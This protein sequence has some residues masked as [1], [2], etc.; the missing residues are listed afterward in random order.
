M[1]KICLTTF[2]VCFVVATAFAQDKGKIMV[3]L[4]GG[5]LG[6]GCTNCTAF[7]GPEIL[8]SYKVNEKI[9]ATLNLGFFSKSGTS[10]T[11]IGV[12]GDYYLKGAYNGFYLAPDLTY[13]TYSTSSDITVG[14]NL[15]WGIV[16][17]DSWRIKPHFGYGT[18]FDGAKGRI[19][20]GLQV[21]FII[22]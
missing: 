9:A 6:A 22:P 12:S 10:V 17:A 15:G 7:S 3:G 19:T 14:L 2:I 18:W 11:A 13:I 1:K 16:V 8:G 5:I 21:G 4:G 20:A